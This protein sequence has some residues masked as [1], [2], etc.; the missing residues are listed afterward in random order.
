MSIEDVE[1]MKGLA[2]GQ[3]LPVLHDPYNG[4]YIS[5]PKLSLEAGLHGLHI[6]EPG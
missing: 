2:A 4:G 5:V 3:E 1:N 6:F